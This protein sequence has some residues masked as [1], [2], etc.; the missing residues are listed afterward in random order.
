MRDA[1][2][3]QADGLE[4][5]Y[6][7]QFRVGLELFRNVPKHKH[8]TDDSSVLTN[9]RSNRLGNVSFRT[10]ASNEQIVLVLRD[11]FATL[12]RASQEICVRRFAFTGNGLEYLA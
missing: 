1:A 4:F 12:H 3:E 5:A 7:K 6:L 2:R 10:I 8:G 9:D 11:D